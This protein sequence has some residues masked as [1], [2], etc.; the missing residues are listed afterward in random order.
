MI[1]AAEKKSDHLGRDKVVREP[2]F[3]KEECEELK[4]F[5]TPIIFL[6]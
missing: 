4:Y 1:I 5:F 2:K 6:Y 3:Y